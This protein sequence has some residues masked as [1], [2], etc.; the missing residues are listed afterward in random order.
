MTP[1]TSK[2]RCALPWSV[3]DRECERGKG[4]SLG[5]PFFDVF[6]NRVRFFASISLRELKAAY[7]L[8]AEG[9][10]HLVGRRPGDIFAAGL[11]WVFSNS[12]VVGCRNLR[13][14]SDGASCTQSLKCASMRISPL[15]VVRTIRKRA[16][17]NQ[18]CRGRTKAPCLGSVRRLFAVSSVA[19][20]RCRPLP[21]YEPD[22]CPRYGPSPAR[23]VPV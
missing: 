11:A 2:V 14:G 18:R 22:A 9:C 13:V 15:Y 6:C 17:R 20:Q 21:A 1:C 5:F 7:V 12:A 23:D 19:C 4:K 3:V 16:N 8:S 10:V